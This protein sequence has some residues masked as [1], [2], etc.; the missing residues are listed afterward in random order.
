MKA[1]ITSNNTIASVVEDNE[2]FEV[3]EQFKWVEC[4]ENFTDF[5]NWTYTDGIFKKKFQ[6]LPDLAPNIESITTQQFKMFLSITRVGKNKET[7]F[8]ILKEK[9]D[10]L[11]ANE[12]S[13][14]E[15]SLEFCSEVRIQDEVVSLV[16]EAAN[17]SEGQVK[18][19]F[20][21]CSKF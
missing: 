17:F 7:L 2:V 21:F 6:G 11:P 18:D 20:V 9:I 14:I 15:L 16:K 5:W 10:Q 12:K 13:G 8:S 3:H 19:M 4:H 1:L